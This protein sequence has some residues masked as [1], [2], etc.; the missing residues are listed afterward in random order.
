[1]NDITDILNIK[2]TRPLDATF[3]KPFIHNKFRLCTER[4]NT[5]FAL[6]RSVH[7]LSSIIDTLI[8]LP[9]IQSIDGEKYLSSN[10]FVDMFFSGTKLLNPD[11]ITSTRQGPSVEY[12]GEGKDKFKPG[13]NSVLSLHC[14]FWPDDASEWAQR[15][16][17][18][19]WPTSSD[20][21][22]IID[23]GCHLVPV[24][25]PHSDTKL[26][27]WRISFS[28]AERTLV[29]SFNH[30]QIQCYA[31]MKLILKEFI[32]KRCSKQNQVLGS[33]FIKTF[34]FWKFESTPFDFWSKS[35]FR[36]CIKYLL[37]EFSKCI[38]EGVLKHYFLPKFN[39]LSLKLT[40]EAQTELLYL[41]DIIIQSD[42]HILNDC[43]TLKHVWSKFLSADENQMNI[44]HR[45]KRRSLLGDDIL[46]MC[47]FTELNFDI[48]SQH[49]TSQEVL[50]AFNIFKR[51]SSNSIHLPT[52]RD[53]FNQLLAVPCKS[54]LNNFMMKQLLLEKKARSL[55]EIAKS[56]SK[57]LSILQEIVNESTSFDISTS[58][59][60]YAI[61]LL[62]KCD[63]TSTLNIV[64][65]VLSSIPQFAL[66]MLESDR[67]AHGGSNR[68][69]LD[70]FLNSSRTAMQRAREAWLMPL[71]IHKCV[72][73]ALPLAMKIE[74]H[75]VST[76][77]YSFYVSPYTC[78]YYLLFQCYHELGQYDSRDGVLK[79]LLD[80]VDILQQ[81]DSGFNVY[82]SLN[83]VGHC[84]LTTGQREQARE[85]FRKSR[86]ITQP[87]LVENQRNSANFYIANYC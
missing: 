5:G 83:I 44:I 16:R 32:N 15:P 64:N 18:F 82:H 69:Y 67:R 29:W 19:G 52:Y 86:A 3:H 26:I 49:T 77:M 17:E 62:K 27:E 50:K 87:F 24:G 14:Q 80:D 2:V 85:I 63:Y 25:H 61:F 71:V 73:E 55:V 10:R 68:F 33:Y 78:A 40:M 59:L 79:Q 46:M 74:H 36:E 7:L 47:K 39:L 38:R 60:W 30:I 28:L 34:L 11:N 1:M 42:I 37:A 58:K 56:D 66:H 65:Q 9:N 70:K 84:L 45:S 4:T 6:L 13:S 21:S 23:L 76:S 8:L 22:S 48:D 53:S 81:C 72:S 20:I 57:D 12:W 54:H 43:K 75:F 41:F 35:N 31:V 51:W